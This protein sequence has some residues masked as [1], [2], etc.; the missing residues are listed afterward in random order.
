MNAWATTI[1]SGLVLVVAFMQWRTAHQKVMLD[2]F[3]RRIK[4]FD[5]V[6]EGVSTYLLDLGTMSDSNAR[7]KIYAAWR[8][9]K[10]VF[11]EDVSFHINSVLK[12]IGRL[13]VI[14]INLHQGNGTSAQR[15][16]L[17][18]EKKPSRCFDYGFSNQNDGIV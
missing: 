6:N 10:F 9:S 14:A 17:V 11:G 12:A 18:D 3:S 5:D 7:A 8:E 15:Q 2:L 1:I 4:I 16:D 13:K